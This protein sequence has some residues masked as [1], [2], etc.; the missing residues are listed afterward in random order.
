MFDLPRFDVDAIVDALRACRIA[1]PRYSIAA[2]PR[3]RRPFLAAMLEVR[4]VRGPIRDFTDAT[5]AR[6]YEGHG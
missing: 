1:E 2:K 6:G 5:V 3:G 4:P